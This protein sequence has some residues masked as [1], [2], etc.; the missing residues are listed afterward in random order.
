MIKDQFFDDLQ[1]VINS[2]PPDDL[3]IVMGD[4]NARFWMWR[5]HGSIMVGSRGYI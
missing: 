4:F 3:L 2:S 5:R 1:V